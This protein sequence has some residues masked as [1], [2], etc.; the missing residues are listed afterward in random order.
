VNTPANR[1]LVVAPDYAA[2]KKYVDH[3]ADPRLLHTYADGPSRFAGRTFTDEHLIFLDGWTEHPKAKE[4][5]A[6]VDLRRALNGVK[7]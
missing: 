5:I 7:K 3:E 4:I 2:F 1:R 6:Q